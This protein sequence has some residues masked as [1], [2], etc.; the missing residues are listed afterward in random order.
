MGEEIK[1]YHIA[2][3]LLSGLSDSYV[4]FVPVYDVCPDDKLILQYVKCK[5]MDE[6]KNRMYKP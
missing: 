4:T 6:S 3:L 5:L 2:A 1:D